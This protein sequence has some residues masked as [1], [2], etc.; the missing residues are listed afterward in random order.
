MTKWRVYA[1]ALVL[2]FFGGG[3]AR[4]DILYFSDYTVGT[5]SMSIALTQYAA[6]HPGTNIY[7]TSS[8]TTFASQLASGKYNLAVF[9]VQGYYSTLYPAGVSALQTFVAGGGRAIADNWAVPAGPSFLSSFGATFAG[10]VNNTQFTVT[11]PSLNPGTYHLSN[12]GWGIF[13]YDLTPTSGTSAG[14][15]TSNNS[16]IVVGNG[17]RTI[18]NG[19]LSDTLPTNTGSGLYLAEI[20]RVYGA[21]GTPEPSTITLFGVGAVGVAGCTWRRRKRAA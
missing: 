3:A 18:V 8:D 9:F 17:G 4:A 13:S 6:A 12:P 20:N 10:P 19:F 21:K 16:A 14:N 5:D 15:F 11:D 1:A 2:L 7:T